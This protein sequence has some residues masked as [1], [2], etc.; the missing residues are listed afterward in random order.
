[1]IET[2]LSTLP[3]VSTECLLD[4]IIMTCKNF[5]IPYK[6]MTALS[7]INTLQNTVKAGRLPPNS[8]VIITNPLVEPVNLS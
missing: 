1:M 7:I 3:Q 8:H 5:M 6:K 2:R 4:L